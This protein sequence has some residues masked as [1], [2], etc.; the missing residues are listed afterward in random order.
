MKSTQDS[1][2]NK[3]EI[4]PILILD[5][6]AIPSGLEIEQWVEL[7]KEQGIAFYDSTKGN[8]PFY[9]KPNPEI[10]MYDVQEEQAM[11]ELE[12]ILA[13]D[14]IKYKDLEPIIPQ[15]APNITQTEVPGEGSLLRTEGM[16]EEVGVP[17]NITMD[18]SNM[19]TGASVD[20]SQW[21][22]QLA[23]EMQGGEVTIAGPGIIQQIEDA[24]QV[25][26]T[27]YLTSTDVASLEVVDPRGEN[28]TLSQAENDLINDTMSAQAAPQT[29]T[30]RRGPSVTRR[31]ARNSG[32]SFE[33]TDDTE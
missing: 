3:L 28:P 25:S 15:S 9:S 16:F 32:T 14:D 23:A 2:E 10:K 31:I 18:T 1:T 24:S 22:T 7:V 13:E 11:S 33:L 6:A 26:V 30:S 27:S 4:K 29:L 8:T 19:V 5:V 17:M 12:S 21:S 20:L